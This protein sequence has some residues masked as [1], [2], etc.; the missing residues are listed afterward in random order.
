MATQSTTFTCEIIT[1]MFAG[2]ALPGDCELRPTA[3]KGALR[4][5]WRAMNGD[6]SLPDLKEEEAEI[7][8]SSGDGEGK[9]KKSKV[10]VEVENE[11]IAANMPFTGITT[12][13]R[14]INKSRL[15]RINGGKPL[16]QNLNLPEY[17]AFGAVTRDSYRSYFMP[18][19]TK[20]FRIKLL[21]PDTLN[22]LPIKN[23]LTLCSVFGGLGA[24]SRNG[25]GR[26]KV[27]N[28]TIDE[29]VLVDL[30]HSTAGLSQFTSISTAT[31]LFALTQDYNSWQEILKEI[32]EKYFKARV[33]YTPNSTS[34]NAYGIEAEHD[35]EKRP[36]LGAPLPVNK[37]D[38][39]LKT[40]A[41][42]SLKI[43][44]HAKTHFFGVLKNRNN[45]SG[46]ILHL[47]Y[48]FL[49][50]YQEV[51]GRKKIPV[52]NRSNYKAQYDT[53]MSDFN[54]ALSNP[55]KLNMRVV[56]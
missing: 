52:R 55:A 53:V 11:Y 29:N 46:Y 5:W 36:Y 6:K 26:F 38:Q 19:S 40:P 14:Y 16:P 28:D 45:Y 47:P 24:K 54:D 17:L 8:G 9:G 15:P 4:F 51:V 48:D 27:H 20:R 50:G 25:F 43:E 2:S 37:T 34:R 41:G 1:P 33:K 32:G 23:A 13:P 12:I 7:F 49:N 18:D 30:L 35:Y 39:P 3:I 21:H 44:R 22:T 56:I 31:R 42:D 10:I